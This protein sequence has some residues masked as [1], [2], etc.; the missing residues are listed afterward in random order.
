MKYKLIFL[1]SICSFITFAQSYKPPVF[2]DANRS[3]KIAATF[4]VIDQLYKDYAAANH[5]PGLAYGIVV[6]GQLVHT[7]NIGYTDLVNKT[8]ASSKS[9]FRIASMTKS[10]TAMAILKLRD[11]GKLKLDDPA[12]MYVPE[13]KNSKLLTKDASAITIRNLLTHAAGY[14]E[15][16][17][18]GDRQLADSDEELLN[19]YRKGLSFSND[20]GLGYE[21]SNLGFATLGYIIKKV[22]GK[23]YEDYITENIL[24]PLGMNHTYWE[25]TKVP[26]EQ[27]ALGYRWLNNEWVEQ[28]LLHDGSYGAMGGLITTIEDFSKYMALHMAAR[29]PR[30]DIETGPVKRSSI[31]EMQ[32]PWDVSALNLAAKLTNGKPCPTV[33]AYCYGLRWTKD[34]DNRIYV[35][36]TGGLP[37]FGSQWNIL[38]EYGIGIVSF[39]NLTYANAGFPNKQALDT[40]LALSGI[41]PR[42]LPASAI[43]NKRKSELIKLLP[44]WDNAKASNIFAQNFWMDYFPDKLKAE[45]TEA[46][47]KAGKIT[48][49]SEIIALNQLRGSFIMQGEK[50]NIK[51]SFTLTPE[52]P[53]LIQ[54]YHLEVLGN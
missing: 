36:H 1:F 3:K 20:P 27:L 19:I 42:V 50:A 29:P 33:S 6:D 4:D 54:E 15:D 31:R 34:C 18:W 43:L 11:E 40:L 17:P 26:K 22:S 45:A 13:M 35:G 14:P 44:N 23:T 38:P 41:Q 2:T 47:A 48:G 5:W 28:P 53:A 12:S 51:I 24:K 21:Y 32:Y 37:G 25:Y 52:N 49:L 9:A 7:G 16:N 30:D 10:F 39:V 8:A 46:F